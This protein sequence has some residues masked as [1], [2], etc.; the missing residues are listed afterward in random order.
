VCKNNQGFTLIEFLVAIV[1][2]MV[3]MLG[4]LQSVNVA[5]VNNLKTQ[6]RNEGVIVADLYMA[7]EMGKT[8]TLIS[9]ATANFVE[10]RQILQSFN[11]YSVQRSGTT[12]SN[13]KQV[14]FTV[15]WHHRGTRYTNETN[16][17][18]STTQ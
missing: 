10:R 11:N 12:L 3:G 13:S 7:R 5:L 9:T 16:S 6:L 15:S 4:L 17:I 18:V 1:I 14:G 8:F 2:L